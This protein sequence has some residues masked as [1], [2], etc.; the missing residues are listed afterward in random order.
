HVK[1]LSLDPAHVATFS[2]PIVTGLLR[3]TMG[4]GGV[5]FSDDL[6]MGAVANHTE[7][8]KAACMS[9][10]AGCD[11][12]LVCRNRQAALRAR[13]GLLAEAST[14]PSMRELVIAAATRFVA[15]RHRFGPQASASDSAQEAFRFEP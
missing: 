12:V 3:R 10:R 4:F 9:I 2:E 14:S 5:V 7:I 15:L 6:E 8:E 11:V 13:A 1:Y